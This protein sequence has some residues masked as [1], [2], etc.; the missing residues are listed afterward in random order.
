LLPYVLCYGDDHRAG[1]CSAETLPAIHNV[2][3][4]RNLP[5]ALYRLASVERVTYARLTRA[6]VKS[7]QF[8]DRCY[9]PAALEHRQHRLMVCQ[10]I[11]LV[12]RQ[13]LIASN[14]G[15]GVPCLLR[16]SSQALS[17]RSSTRTPAMGARK[18]RSWND[19]NGQV[20]ET[21]GRGALRFQVF[22]RGC[23]ANRSPA[24]VAHRQIS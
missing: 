10:D 13:P 15:A 19:D 14:E 24:E 20:R 3:P 22:V 12:L 7:P 17:C 1:R 6:G 23:L 2:V 5:A 9:R 11:G 4:D 16:V 8:P 21:H 18:L